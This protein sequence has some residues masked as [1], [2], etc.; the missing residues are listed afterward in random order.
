MVELISESKPKARK[1]H[2][3][4]SCQRKIPVGAVYMNQFCKDGGNVWSYKE[5]EDCRTANEIIW[6][7]GDYSYDDD[8]PRVCDYEPEDAET[9]REINPNLAARLKL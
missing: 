5:C 8:W 4:D 2:H 9:I 6:D 1:P 3:C 7:A